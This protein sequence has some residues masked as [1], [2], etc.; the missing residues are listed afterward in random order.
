MTDLETIYRERY[1][2]SL[3]GI[4]QRLDALIQSHLSGLPHI[5]RIT[6]RV[7]EPD[8]F[9]EKAG[10]LDD[11]GQPKYREPLTQIQDQVGARVVVFCLSDVDGVLETLGRYFQPI[12]EKLLVPESHWEF[13]YFGHHSVC[14]LP[15]D[16]VPSHV[17]R[18]DAPRF[19]ELQI[20][21]L[22]Q[23]AWSEANHDL[24]YK[25]EIGL[26]GEQERYLAF[27]AAQAWGADKAFEDLR[28]EL[29][30]RHP[31]A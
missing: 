14:A 16:V 3:V 24:G 26:S 17:D 21:T 28:Q 8:S 31:A 18:A 25:P 9:A 12:E 20:K 11:N 1:A 7:K 15:G 4:A 22:F 29:S 23:H 2:T 6:V 5:D 13:G 19:F 27:A 30:E 10:R